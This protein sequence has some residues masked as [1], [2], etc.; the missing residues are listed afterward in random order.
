MHVNTLWWASSCVLSH[1]LIR[2]RS[3]WLGLLSAARHFVN[4]FLD[5][6]RICMH[7]WQSLTKCWWN[8]SIFVEWFYWEFLI[9]NVN[10]Y[11]IFYRYF[12]G[13]DRCARAWLPHLSIYK[14]LY[15]IML[16]TPTQCRP[17]HGVLS[18]ILS[19]P[20]QLSSSLSPLSL[21]SL[22]LPLIITKLLQRLKLSHEP[23]ASTIGLPSFAVFS[24]SRTLAKA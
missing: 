7:D 1:D 22:S 18:A 2:L 24:G 5:T 4:Y 16:L 17:M 14:Q 21:L 12:C 9:K 13:R 19:A 3:R 15:Y 20:H 8:W 6:V 10:F 23:H 11:S